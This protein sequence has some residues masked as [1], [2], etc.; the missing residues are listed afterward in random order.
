MILDPDRIIGALTTLSA[1]IRRRFPDAGLNEACE[2]VLSIARSAKRRSES[3]SRPI[4]SLRVAVGLLVLALVA[5]PI[6]ATVNFDLP[7]ESLDLFT[8]AEL[9]DSATRDIALFAVAVFFLVTL[10]TRIKRTRVLRAI[11]ELRNAACI[12]DMHQLAKD[13]D[14]VSPGPAADTTG[15]LL[16]RHEMSRYLEYC[17][18]L[19]ALTGKISA[20][21]IQHFDDAIAVQ[22]VNEIE[23]LTAGLSQKILQ[24]ILILRTAERRDNAPTI[25]A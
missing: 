3:I 1:R 25:A 12:I 16:T 11:R 22:A 2:H 19:L 4:I 23:N 10:E 6:V 17:N 7:P 20:V 15:E 9:F 8:L 18:E 21:Y 24:K 13:P 5:T 14:R